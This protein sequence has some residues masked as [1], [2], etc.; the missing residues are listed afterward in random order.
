MLRCGEK[1]L[2]LNGA[3]QI[4]KSFIIRHE[5]TK[6]FPNYIEIDLLEDKNRKFL[7]L[8]ISI[9]ALIVYCY[10]G[11]MRQSAESIFA[12]F[13]LLAV[14]ITP[15]LGNYLDHKGKG[16]S[17]L[18]LGA[19]LLIICHLTFAFVLPLFKGSAVGGTVVAYAT[20][21]V[22]GA[23]FSLVPAALW[24]S[25]PKL[26]ELREPSDGQF[27][28]HAVASFY[29]CKRVFI[30]E[31]R[32]LCD[33]RAVERVGDCRDTAVVFE[34]SEKLGVIVAVAADVEP[35]LDDAVREHAGQLL[36][37]LDDVAVNV[38]S[39]AP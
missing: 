14:L 38:R 39:L 4:G 26:V 15:I 25:V 16:A 33:R 3:R 29:V 31:I 23:S 19:V 1:I 11:Y 21:L 7:F 34:R 18:V 35:P 37:L 6:R 8:G 2:I 27:A 9:A 30:N 13:P 5:G 28:P 36:V 17:M 24:P 20:I 10:M 12:V 22:L 32:R